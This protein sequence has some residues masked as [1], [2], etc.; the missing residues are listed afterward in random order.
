MA[1]ATLD[2]L[3]GYGIERWVSCY[4]TYIFEHVNSIEML[5]TD[6]GNY[7]RQ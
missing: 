4:I 2:T 7:D 1:E 6:N 5:S 3:T